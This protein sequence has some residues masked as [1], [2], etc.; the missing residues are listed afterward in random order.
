MATTHLRLR[1]WVLMAERG[2][3]RLAM[4]TFGF[5]LMVVGLGLGITMIMLPPGIVIG[6]GGVGLAVI[7]AIGD[8]PD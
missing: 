6:L 7:G 2:T 4:I 1:R 5:V 8:F 3:V